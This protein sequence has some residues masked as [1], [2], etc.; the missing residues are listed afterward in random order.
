MGADELGSV[1]DPH[2]VIRPEAAGADEGGHLAPLHQSLQ[3]LPQLIDHLLLAG[4]GLGELDRRR[5]DDDPELLGSGDGAVDGRGL[6]E[7]L[8]RYATAMQAGAA[9]LFLL[10]H[11]DVESGQTAAQGC[12]IA[13]RTATDDNDV[14]L[15]GRRDHLLRTSSNVGRLGT[16]SAG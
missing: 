16:C 4:L 13:G 6:E 7:L 3:T 14:E 12:G 5:V 8:G 1:V 15:L 11:G 2:H 9:N 10:D